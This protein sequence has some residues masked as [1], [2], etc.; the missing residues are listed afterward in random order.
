MSKFVFIFIC[1]ELIY[2]K[3][4]EYLSASK[5]VWVIEKV[6]MLSCSTNLNLNDHCCDGLNFPVM[7]S[8]TAEHS[9]LLNRR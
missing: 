2:S 1:M 5:S 6:K 4:P 9:V 7:F 3:F 8:L